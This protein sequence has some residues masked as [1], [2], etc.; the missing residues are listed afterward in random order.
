MPRPIH[1]NAH[2]MAIHNSGLLPESDVTGQMQLLR[3][4]LDHLMSGQPS[5]RVSWM[6]MADA[7]NMTET[8]AGMRIG[9]GDDA[10]RVIQEAQESLAEAWQA[11]EKRGTWAMSAQ[12][13][14]TLQERLE[15]LLVLHETQMLA[16]SIREYARAFERTRARMAAARRGQVGRGVVVVGEM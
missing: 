5:A 16:V 8:L 14:Q 7:A 4:H 11:A 1:L 10:E 2:Q 15:W 13:R 9:G 12:A 3:E 6:S